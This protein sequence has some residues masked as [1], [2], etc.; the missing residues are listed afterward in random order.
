MNILIIGAGKCGVSLIDTFS[1]SEKINIAGVVDIRAD[2]PGIKLA[3]KIGIPTSKDYKKFIS[4]NNIHEVFNLT[5]NSDV[6]SDLVN[7]LPSSIELVSGGSAKLMR[8]VIERHKILSEELSYTSE[9]YKRLTEGL[10]D[11]VIRVSPAGIVEYCSP[12]VGEFGGYDPEK[13][14]GTYIGKYFADKKDLLKALK[15]I[16]KAMIYKEGTSIEFLYQPKDKEPF[17]VEATGKPIVRNGKVIT[18][19]CVM[20]D[21]SKRKSEEEALKESEQRFRRIIENTLELSWELDK[22]GLF[23]YVNASTEKILGFKSKELIEKKHLHDLFHEEERAKLKKE[24]AAIFSRKESFSN[25]MVHCMCKNGTA[26]W[27]QI[28]GTPILDK[29]DNLVGYSGC[30]TNITVSVLVEKSIKKS[31]Q[32]LS[33]IF[34]SATDGICVIDKDF[35][36]IKVNEAFCSQ[37]QISKDKVLHKKCHEVYNIPI[38]RTKECSLTKIVSGDESGYY[39]IEQKRKNGSKFWCSVSTAPFKDSDGTLIGIVKILKDITD[40]KKAE[41]DIAEAEQTYSELVN[42]LQVGVFRSTPGAKGKFLEINPALAKIFEA[43][44]REEFVKYSAK[45]FYQNSKERK[46]LSDKLLKQGFVKNEKLAMVTLKG[47]KIWASVTIVTKKDKEGKQYFYGILQDISDRIRVEERLRESQER[48]STIISNAHAILYILDFDS[49]FTFVSPTWTSFLGHKVSE[50]MG[51]PISAFIHPDDLDRC[52]NIIKHLISTEEPVKDIEHRIRHKNGRWR[53]HAT[54]VTLVKDRNGKPQYLLGVATDISDRKKAEEEAG[55]AEEKY[56][57]V[58]ENSAVAIM[59]VDDKERIVSWNKFTEELLGFKK[60]DLYL[61]SV[62]SLYPEEEWKKIRSSNIRKKGI[63]HHYETKIIKKDKSLMDVD[64]SISVLKDPEG[65]V[66]GSIGIIQDITDRKKADREI[67]VAEEKYRTIFENSAVAIMMV[68]DQERITSWNDF[69][70]KLL[71][72]NMRDLYL[73]PVSSL[74][75]KEAWAEIRA[76][77]LRQKGFHHHFETKTIKKNNELIDVDMSISVLRDSED[78]VIGSVGI[79]R[80]ITDRKQVDKLKDEFVSTVSHELRTPLTTIREGVSQVLEGLLGKVNKEQSE[81]LSIALSDIDRLTRIINNLLDISRI[82]AGRAM[83]VRD[84]VDIVALAKKT[85][86]SFAP[87]VTSRGIELKTSIPDKQIDVYV[88]SDRII[89]VFTNLIGNS[90]KFTPKGHIEVSIKEKKEEVEC[91]VIDTGIGVPEDSIPN[92]FDKFYQVGRESGPGYRGTGLGLPITK[93]IIELH[94]GK[95][96]AESKVEKGTKFIFVLP[97]YST[98]VLLLE[99]VGDAIKEAVKQ[100]TSLSM[101]AF[102]I[103]NFKEIEKTLGTEKAN[104]IIHKFEDLSKKSLRRRADLATKDSESVLIMLPATGKLDALM[105]VGRILKVFEEFLSVEQ[106]KDKVSI[107]H[108]VAGYP[109]DGRTEEKLIEMVW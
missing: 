49:N 64:I 95:I 71:G 65:K 17:Y 5:K 63:Q 6:H 15:L 68:D 33:E 88:D 35:N 107:K 83:V 103:D 40:K 32:E 69:T 39:E 16:G 109:E 105:V 18:I 101:I 27:F 19:Q 34:N 104:Y 77:N 93:G 26:A 41:A 30:G 24:I 56:R 50:I 47:R 73:K 82:E 58:F 81:F 106:L 43:D 1:N 20:R 13:V 108:K 62:R 91:S 60:E 80:D 28:S 10:K 22:N 37:L 67:R 96:W 87:Q 52:Q 61:S 12:V 7:S 78:K 2:A 53:W 3:K 51:K 8:E 76:R 79:M 48:L 14:V 86:M 54:Y 29:K 102:R 23:T 94:H 45:E 75:T 72:M 9:E 89:Q 98:K 100:G 59:M 31:Y 74:Y 42:N 25:F 46:K 85:C 57:T 36:I 99:Q 66:T 70:E 21:I 55:I 44:S 84:V 11:V 92:L 38:C 90:L 4:K 97:K